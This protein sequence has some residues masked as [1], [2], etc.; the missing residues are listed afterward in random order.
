MLLEGC[1]RHRDFPAILPQ[2]PSRLSHFSCNFS[3]WDWTLHNRHPPHALRR[4]RS[5]RFCVARRR[6][7]S[8]NRVQSAKKA[9]ADPDVPDI[10]YY[11]PQKSK[12]VKVLGQGGMS[13][14]WL[15]DYD[16][17][18]LVG[19]YP[20]PSMD[21]QG[22]KDMFAAAHLQQRIRH[23]NVLRVV[24]V[25]ENH[26]V[27]LLEVAEG[28][29]LADWYGKKVDPMVQWKVAREVAEALNALHTMKPPVVHRDLKGQNVFLTKDQVGCASSGGGGGR[30]GGLACIGTQSPPTPYPDL[31]EVK[32]IAVWI[33]NV[34]VD[35]TRH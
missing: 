34:L 18:R 31:V 19:K 1:R 10:F 3:Q 14:A 16:G 30:W 2:C 35:A 33:L 20:L 26:K 23:R 9:A 29:D 13:V 15:L 32:G 6:S 8:T 17:H 11:E 25:S 28:G 21:P 7:S 12:K 27:I 5:P 4:L 24:G 22:V